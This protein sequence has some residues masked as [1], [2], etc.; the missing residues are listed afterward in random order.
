MPRSHSAQIETIKRI[1]NPEEPVPRAVA[2]TLAL[3]ACGTG[4]WTT[5]T[6]LAL[7][8]LWLGPARL[9]VGLLGGA[10]DYLPHH[11]LHHVPSEDR[12]KTTRNRV[13][14]GPVLTPLLRYQN[15]HL[16][17]HLHPVIPFD[18]YIAMWRRRESEYLAHEP[19]LASPRGRP[20]TV[21]EYR[22]LRAMH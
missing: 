16:V 3:F 21:D 17:H 14:A 11:G 18:R 10:F 5:S 19:P 9:A 13:G 22:A 8:G 6:A 1:P 12:F 2:P 4:I 7:F 20:L 15:Y